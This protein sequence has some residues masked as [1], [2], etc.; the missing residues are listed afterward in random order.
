MPLNRRAQKH[1]ARMR[2]L[3]TERM[4]RNIF[5]RIQAGL[6][7]GKVTHQESMQLIS[8]FWD[9]RRKDLEIL[10]RA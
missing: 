3:N 9:E 5:Q 7:A 6:K 4:R 1:A 8:E 10:R 2:C